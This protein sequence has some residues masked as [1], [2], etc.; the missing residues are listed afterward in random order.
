MVADGEDLYWIESRPTEGGRSVIVT[1]AADGT[2]SDVSPPGFNSRTRAHE[3]GGGGYAVHA[4]VIVSAQFGDQRVYRLDGSEPTA[5]TPEPL[6]SAGDRYADFEFFGSLVIAVRERHHP[7]R[8]PDNEIVIFPFD[9]SAEPR[10]IAGGHDFVSTPKVSPDG[11]RLAWLTWD[12][13]RMPWEGTEL[14]VADLSPDGTIGH[15]TLVAGSAGESVYQPEWSPTGEL[16]FV[17]DRSGWWNL[18]RQEP[19]GDVTLLVGDEAEW[20]SPQWVFGM[21]NY[22]F[23]PDGRIVA[24]VSEKGWSRFVIVD[25]ASVG[26]LYSERD[27]IGATTLAVG[28]GRVWM[29]AASA[30]EAAGIVGVDPDSGQ[31][32]EIRSSL[33]VDLDP[34]YVS[35]AEAISF[36]TTDGA[37]AHA[38]YYPPTNPD[39]AGS[40]G[41][42]PPLI[43]WSHGG[44]TGAS[45]PAL[46]LGRQFWTTRGFAI[47][48]VNYRGSVGFGR[49]YR[50]ALVGR[51][52]E[53]DTEDCIAAA[54]YL[55][56]QGLADP[57]RLAI[58]GGSAG[59]YTTLCAL[60]FHDVFATGASYFGV[61]DLGALAEET[62]KFES[63][64]MD[65]MIGPYPEAIELYRARSP[66]HHVDKLSRPMI[67]LQGL[68]DKVVLPNQAEMMVEALT[69]KRIPHAYVAF[70]GEGHGFR[71]ADNIERAAE[72]ELAFYGWVFGFDPAGDIR[73]PEIKGA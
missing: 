30:T 18:Y 54:H 73:R 16:H 48:D 23:L 49:A 1:R 64:Y 66:I 58:R 43:V 27:A 7:D 51:W 44:P 15:P 19:T 29:V 8:E 68:D 32:E 63:R 53:I 2:I 61:A 55:V 6:S 42:L 60:T 71:S 67:I 13:P 28:G 26:A 52:G 72:A 3:Y 35:R 24:I 17:S 38:F 12:H 39:F 20:G 57:D 65:S 5:I 25:G 69:K 10:V 11:R 62:H 41:E 40:D 31:S 21:V 33:S 4:G 70:E 47:V 56:A 37:I 34:A 36:P 22:R 14:W 46:L 45:S 59:G 9:G 50:Q